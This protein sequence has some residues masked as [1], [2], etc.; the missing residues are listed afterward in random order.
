[1]SAKRLFKPSDALDVP[2]PTKTG[3]EEGNIINPPNYAQF[4]G[5]DSPNPR[6]LKRNDKTISMPGSTIKKVPVR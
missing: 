5:L 6:G 1:M 4:G 2:S 3:Q